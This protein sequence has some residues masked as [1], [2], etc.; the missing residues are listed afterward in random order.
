MPSS[1][2]K[3]LF[4]F[5]AVGPPETQWEKFAK[6]RRWWNQWVWRAGRLRLNSPSSSLVGISP[7]SFFLRLLRD[8][9]YDESRYE[10]PR[11]SLFSRLNRGLNIKISNLPKKTRH[12]FLNPKFRIDEWQLKKL[13]TVNLELE[14]SRLLYSSYESSRLKSGSRLRLYSPLIGDLDRERFFF[15]LEYR[16][17]SELDRCRSEL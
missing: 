5:V 9:R 17:S 15:L 3:F 2:R 7:F 12:K 10:L 13:R 14:E 11:F 6:S 1:L 8:E 16:E 4:Y